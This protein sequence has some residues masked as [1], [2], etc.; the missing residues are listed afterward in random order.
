MSQYMNGLEFGKPISKS[1][2]KDKNLKTGMKKFVLCTIDEA[3]KIL[4]AGPPQL[5][6]LAAPEDENKEDLVRY[7]A[8][9]KLRFQDMQ[10]LHMFDYSRS[11]ENSE[12][13]AIPAAKAVQMYES[14]R[15]LVLNSLNIPMSPDEAADDWMGKIPGWDFAQRICEEGKKQGLDLS[16]L[17]NAFRAILWA[18][19][20]A[21]TT[22]HYDHHGVFTSIKPWS[23]HKIWIM[24]DYGERFAVWVPPGYRLFQRSGTPHAVLTQEENSIS[25]CFMYWH[26]KMIPQ[27]LDRT[28]SELCDPSTTND[29]YIESFVPAMK[30]AFTLLEMD[31][32]GTWLTESEIAESK[33]KLEVR[34]HYELAFKI[35][36]QPDYRGVER[37]RDLFQVQHRK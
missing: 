8:L 30:I 34:Y 20:R 29:D 10:T 32:P 28:L 2:Y 22:E 21:M 13:E 19:P 18:T 27:I 7:C 6:I 5:H 3:K 9:A 37:E 33:E 24:N 11:A 1:N 4:S 14:G 17:E 12:P 36:A 15:G 16:D 25:S 31:G 26:P 23:G 35:N